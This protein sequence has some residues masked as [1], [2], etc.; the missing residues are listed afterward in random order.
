[1]VQEPPNLPPLVDTSNG[2]SPRL[3]EA[4]QEISPEYYMNMPA[5]NALQKVIG[6]F[7]QGAKRVV[8]DVDLSLS[9]VAITL[10][11]PSALVTAIPL[12]EKLRIDRALRTI[13]SV[14]EGKVLV[15]NLRESGIPVSMRNAPIYN[16]AVLVSDERMDGNGNFSKKPKEII[17]PAYSNHGR[18]VSFLI[19]ELQHL[20]QATSGLLEM[21][22][23][24]I[25]SPIEAVWY[26][27]AIEADAKATE[28]D[29]SYKLHQAGHRDA[30]QEE[31]RTRTTPKIFIQAYEDAIAK[32]P[33]AAANGEAKRAAFDAWHEARFSSGTK[34]SE[35]Y[36]WQGVGSWH[37]S[38]WKIHHNQ[39]TVPL[40]PLQA[41]DIR[42]LGALSKVNYL[43]LPNARPLDDPYYR[44]K[45]W[46]AGQAGALAT[47][48]ALYQ[49]KFL[50]LDTNNA[51]PEQAANR[52]LSG[53]SRY[54][55]A[56]TASVADTSKYTSMAYT[57]MAASVSASAKNNPVIKPAPVQSVVDAPA[58]KSKRAAPKV[59]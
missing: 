14:P 9:Q 51:K 10:E 25:V 24:K 19:H 45:T 17:L 48:H 41:D 59:G 57:S 58:A 11:N 49:S 31:N 4:V 46:T 47:R 15:D 32:N 42:K 37:G 39:A 6:Y 30:W 3:A 40:A 18:L 54:T 28:L 29:I 56:L 55:A 27:A 2:T 13:A 33:Q 8:N 5:P 43:D 7:K 21:S 53:T 35:S 26:N 16:G 34:F 1:M 22:E 44:Q 52:D 23:Q 36:T 50:P 12:V 38:A 20:R